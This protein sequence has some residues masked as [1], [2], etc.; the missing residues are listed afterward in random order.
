M[1]KI[2]TNSLLAVLLL[3]GSGDVT[4]ALAQSLACDDGIKTAFRPDADT[5]V[6]AVRLVKQGEELAAGD[7]PKPPI[8]AAADLCLVKLLVGPGVTAEKDKTA[9]SYSEGIGIEVWLPT[10]PIG[11][12]ASAIMAA[13]DGSAADIAIP[14]RSAARSR[15]SSTPI[16]AMRRRPPTRDSPGTRTARSR[17]SPMARSTPRRCATSR[18]GRW[19]SR[20]SRPRRW[21]TCITARRRN[22]PTTTAILRAAARA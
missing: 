10:Q 21:S 7:V 4:P 2:A 22:S 6:V 14:T 19:W 16:W 3:A 15:P 18:C 5:S 11:T 8:I 12:S 17:F 1:T 9:R 20:P 13:A